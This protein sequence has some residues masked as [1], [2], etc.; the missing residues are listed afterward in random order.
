MQSVDA[1]KPLTETSVFMLSKMIRGLTGPS[2]KTEKQK[3]GFLLIEVNQKSYAETLLRTTSLNTVSLEF[4]VRVSPHRTLNS[5]RGTVY[6]PKYTSERV[7]DILAETRDQGVT[8]VT[9]INIRGKPSPLL[10]LK[11]GRVILPSH[12]AIEHERFEVQQDYPNPQRCFKCQKFGHTERVCGRDKVCA[13][14]GKKEEHEYEACPSQTPVCFHC[15]GGHA[16]S[17]KSC[18]EYRR[19]K[20]IIKFKIENSVSFPEARKKFP[21]QNAPLYSTATKS[22]AQLETQEVQTYYT[23]PDH[24]VGRHQVFTKD[25][26]NNL[27]P[28]VYKQ[29]KK[30]VT[31]SIGTATGDLSQKDN[32][33]LKLKQII[34]TQQ[35]QINKLEIQLNHALDP[36]GSTLEDAM[37]ASSS[38]RSTSDLKRRLSSS[39]K[40]PKSDDDSI[41]SL[42]KDDASLKKRR[43]LSKDRETASKSSHST[44]AG[45]A[46]SGAVLNSHTSQVDVVAGKQEPATHSAPG[47]NEGDLVSD[48]PQGDDITD[49]DHQNRE[50]KLKEYEA[51]IASIRADG[52]YMTDELYLTFNQSVSADS[53]TNANRDYKGIIEYQRYLN[54][55]IRHKVNTQNVQLWSQFK[56]S[57]GLTGQKQKTKFKPITWK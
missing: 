57:H 3:S 16:A 30:S 39:D 5:T 33:I 43:V 2:T 21:K 7:E 34:T 22:V 18:P 49:K 36:E 53:K 41:T 54:G 23:F 38:L 26:L 48:V 24:D 35:K 1:D 28:F 20:Q 52:Q 50:A 45:G 12:I 14:C 56:Q 55:C 42:A 27:P 44:D 19:E 11:F 32:E 9:R 51:R 4:P 47:T 8:E 17:S 25:Q 40:P 31:K 13:K 15:G 46:D 6:I 37:D 10:K 29:S